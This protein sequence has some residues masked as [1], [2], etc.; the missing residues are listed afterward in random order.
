MTVRGKQSNRGIRVTITPLEGAPIVINPGADLPY[1][2]KPE[3]LQVSM[4]VK[5]SVGD[6]QNTATVNIANLGRKTRQAII[7]SAQ[8][9]DNYSPGF[10]EIDQ[11]LQENISRSGITTPER[12]SLGIGLAF[13]R[14]EAGYEGRVVE[15]FQGSSRWIQTSFSGPTVSTSIE[16]KDGSTLKYGVC[17]RTFRNTPLVQILAYV[18]DVAGLIFDPVT[19][20]A[21]IQSTIVRSMSFRG[22]P[23]LKAIQ[24]IVNPRNLDWMVDSSQLWILQRD[25]FL[26]FPPLTLSVDNGLRRQPRI[27][28]SGNVEIDAFMLPELRPG[29]QVNLV[30]PE[31]QGSW[32][33]DE[34]EHSG[35]NRGGDFATSAILRSP[36]RLFGGGN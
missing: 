10:Q 36:R 4:S 9:P 3:Q 1:V 28:T 7:S 33:V 17:K 12:I 15:I 24:S 18:A 8:I 21:E 11:R 2:D 34:L 29:L 23:V 25:R 16:V 27:T 26:P 20:P 6:T 5:R 30:S 31:V 32:R 13:V 22:A 14:I 35:D 19:A